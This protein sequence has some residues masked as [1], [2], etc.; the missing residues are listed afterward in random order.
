MWKNVKVDRWERQIEIGVPE[1]A[2]VL[3]SVAGEDK[4]LDPAEGIRRA[5]KNPLGM[6]PIKELVNQKSDNRS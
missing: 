6:A 1:S 2:T 5:L 4:A 3:E